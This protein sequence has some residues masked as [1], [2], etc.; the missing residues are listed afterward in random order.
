MA[1]LDSL[2]VRF[3]QSDSLTLAH[4]S[5]SAAVPWPS[6][7]FFVFSPPFH[8]YYARIAFVPYIW[9]CVAIKNVYICNLRPILSNATQ[10]MTF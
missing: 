10:C 9:M 5:K 8:F 1:K 4:C 6:D 3:W 2:G 7:C